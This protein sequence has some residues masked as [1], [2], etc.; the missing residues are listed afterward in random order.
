[1]KK[2]ND[3]TIP[4]AQPD[5]SRI[6]VTRMI[7]NRCSKEVIASV[8]LEHGKPAEIYL[9]DV[10]QQSLLKAIYVGKV[11]NIVK[12]INAAFI[13]FEKGQVGYYPLEE[14]P[15]AVFT[16]K[17]GK[18]SLVI[19]DELLV[20]VVK[21]PMKTKTAVLT[22]NL[23]FAGKYFVLTTGRK[24]IGIS[25]KI[26][27]ERKKWLK[28][29][30][31]TNM[32][33]S[34]T[35]GVIV[36]TN[37]QEAAEEQLVLEL[38][39][40][41]Q[42]VDRLLKTVSYRTAFSRITEADYEYIR[43]LKNVSF[44]PQSPDPPLKNS[45][46]EE[47]VTDDLKLYHQMKTYL[48]EFQP[49]DIKRLRLYEDPMLPLKKLYNLELGLERALESRVWLKSGAYLVIEPTEAFTVIDVNTGKFDG[50]KQKSDTFLKINLEAALE[51][52][53]QMRLRN[54]SG[55]ILIDFINMEKE[56]DN[57]RLLNEFR[58]YVKADRIQTQV[59]D[60]TEL[61]IVEVTRKK[62]RCSLAET[63]KHLV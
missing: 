43:L 48:E 46:V 8:L 38:N 17:L 54:L 27:G 18:Q 61:G 39:T 11:Q 37:A 33:S 13:E 3:K 25:G 4:P 31:K 45:Y 21:E 59:V 50:R 44:G 35:Y 55:I 34:K 52:A 56:E 49:Q 47:I 9:E 12:N 5:H 24:E 14:L 51:T 20:Q 30:V 57:Q 60:M 63:W 58:H 41:E 19:G 6:L 7:P 29:L 42:S 28:E 15:T 16:K 32:R 1:M 23:N 2:L 22:T 40:L 36:R 53:R 26:K 62:E 10:E